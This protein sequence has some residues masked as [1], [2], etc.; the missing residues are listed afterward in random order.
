MKR[1]LY[2]LIVS[3]LVANCWQPS[4]KKESNEVTQANDIKENPKE[5]FSEEEV[6]EQSNDTII[7][8]KDVQVNE[9]GTIF[10]D[11]HRLIYIE[12]ISELIKRVEDTEIFKFKEIYR[13]NINEDELEDMILAFDNKYTH[14]SATGDIDWTVAPVIVLLNKGN[15]LY[16]M[17]YNSTIYPNSFD[18]YFSNIT[19]KNNFFTVELGNVVPDS[20]DYEKY[21][22]FK[23]DKQKEYLLLHRYGKIIN[24]YEKGESINTQLT[25][26]DFGEISFEE[27][28][29]DTISDLIYK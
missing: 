29:E 6:F 8:P 16:E 11:H 17:S 13:C 7:T 10:Y 26:K 5:D 2:L 14:F 15:N 21:I 27:Y 24:W 3:L 18:D 1:I 12:K 23:Y 28:D 25:T 4:D 9:N 20:Y 19:I 22:T